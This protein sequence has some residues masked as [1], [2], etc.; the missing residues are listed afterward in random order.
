[1]HKTDG[2]RLW[3]ILPV[4]VFVINP[5]G[6]L[7]VGLAMVHTVIYALMEGFAAGVIGIRVWEV[8]SR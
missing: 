7:V 8:G 2:L 5:D 3:H 6:V 1:M 4:S